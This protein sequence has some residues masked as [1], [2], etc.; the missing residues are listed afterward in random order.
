MPTQRLRL[1]SILRHHRSFA[2]PP[3]QLPCTT[4]ASSLQV[5]MDGILLFSNGK[6]EKKLP[7]AG[8]RDGSSRFVRVPSLPMSQQLEERR[9]SLVLVA[10]ATHLLFLLFLFAAGTNAV[11]PDPASIV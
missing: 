7:M 5:N 8:N 10:S 11:K 3:L 6:R 4:T 2:A 9:F 1:Y